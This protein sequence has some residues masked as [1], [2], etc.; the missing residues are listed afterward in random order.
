MHKRRRAVVEEEEIPHCCRCSKEILDDEG[1]ESA[2]ACEQCCKKDLKLFMEEVEQKDRQYNPGHATC[3]EV[4][5]ACSHLCRF[6]FESSDEAVRVHAD[7]GEFFCVDCFEKFPKN[8]CACCSVPI[9]PEASMLEYQS[10]ADV[11]MPCVCNA[12]QYAS[13]TKDKRNQLKLRYKTLRQVADLE[14]DLRGLVGEIKEFAQCRE[15]DAGS[16]LENSHLRT[17]EELQETFKKGQCWK[18]KLAASVEALK[19]WH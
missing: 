2:K 8:P 7:D 11:C 9:M 14:Q 18:E 19:Q 6:K 12:V 5:L 1:V 4:H 15:K 16:M 17:Q 13:Q 3:I 10:E